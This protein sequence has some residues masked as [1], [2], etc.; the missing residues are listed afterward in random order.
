MA[1]GSAIVSSLYDATA[2]PTV[3]AQQNT[4]VSFGG[5]QVLQACANLY[6]EVIL[7]DPS[8]T[9]APA[10]FSVQVLGGIGIA[11]N[12][13]GSPI[14]SPGLVT[15]TATS[16]ITTWQANLTSLSGGVAPSITVRGVAGE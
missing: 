12:P 4:Q 7:T 6:L 8:N 3:G 11:D 2:V 13:I 1:T 16:P 5:S 10:S 15:I 9:G 14:T